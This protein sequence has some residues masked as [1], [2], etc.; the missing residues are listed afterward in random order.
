MRLEWRRNVPNLFLPLSRFQNPIRFQP[1][2]SSMCYYLFTIHQPTLLSEVPVISMYPESKQKLKD[3]ERMIGNIPGSTSSQFQV[4]AHY[5]SWSR[6][7]YSCKH[8]SAIQ[9]Y[10][11][12]YWLHKL[13]YHYSCTSF[14]LSKKLL[15]PDLAL[16]MIWDAIPAFTKIVMPLHST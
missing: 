3:D 11:D 8:V 5:T 13:K 4:I 2:S 15:S 1:R 12:N 10:T 9:I 6:S 14:C 7:K 16:M